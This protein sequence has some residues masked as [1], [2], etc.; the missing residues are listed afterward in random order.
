[1]SEDQIQAFSGPSLEP[2]PAMPSA[3][4]LAQDPERSVATASQSDAASATE[5]GQ[6]ASPSIRE[7]IRTVGMP[8]QHVR[9]AMD[10]QNSAETRTEVEL[11][12]I[13]AQDLA[14]AQHTMRALWGDSYA[15]NVEILKTYLSE[16]VDPAD[17][18]VILNARSADGHALANKP[19][20]LQRLLGQAKTPAPSLKGDVSAQ[21]KSI[22][23]FMRANRAAYNKNEPLQARYRELLDSVGH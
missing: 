21:I 6:L 2:H 13:D 7:L 11:A 14:H 1:M 18:Y 4:A 12:A 20:V 15:S 23:D 16:H 17:A 9:D 3:S 19:D 22:E 5:Q 10:W 8:D